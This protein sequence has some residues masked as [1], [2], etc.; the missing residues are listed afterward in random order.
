MRNLN[1]PFSV[2]TDLEARRGGPP[3]S[4]AHHRMKWFHPFPRRSPAHQSQNSEKTWAVQKVLISSLR[5]SVKTLF[6]SQTWGTPQFRPTKGMKWVH[7]FFHRHPAHQNQN[8]EK[9]HAVQKMLI[10][11]M[12]FYVKASFG[13]Q[14]WGTPQ[15]RP[16]TG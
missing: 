15:V 13:S 2:Q 8:S 11:S 16:T 6:G 5:Y 14:T 1:V 12:R 7:S 4:P 9:T 3:P 10:L